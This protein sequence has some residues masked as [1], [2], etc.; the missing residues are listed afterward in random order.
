MDELKSKLLTPHNN[1]LHTFTTRK[2]GNS[3]SPFDENNLAYH[4]NDNDCDVDKNH[5]NLAAK[6]HYPHNNLIRMNQVHG[7]TIVSITQQTEL[8]T[9]PTCDALITNVKNIPL[10]VMVADCIPLLMYDPVNRA[11]AAIHA[12]R[13]G[14]FSKIVPK[15]ISKMKTLYNTHA[16]DLL[17][18]IGP[19]IHQCCY[20]VGE[21][22]KEEAKE[23][24][25]AYSI[26]EV[27]SSYTLDLLSIVKRQLKA[28]NVNADNI[29]ISTYCTAC[30]TNYFY[31]YRKE[32]KCGRFAGLIMLK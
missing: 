16:N 8:S 28:V 23:L 7:N 9:L 11:I 3:H 22:I 17:I 13:T 25:Y 32:G 26:K 30:S 21:E 19:S 12:G 15:T 20:E 1:L 31:S 4:V 29:D 27:D 5:L 14:V 2:G 24:G 6:L 18:A 10:M